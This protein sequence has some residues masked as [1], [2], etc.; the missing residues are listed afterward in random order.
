MHVSVSGGG[1]GNG[2]YA[3]EN[4]LITFE[5]GE[6]VIKRIFYRSMSPVHGGRMRAGLKV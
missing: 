6:L 2:E 3:I 1:R 5:L 4:G